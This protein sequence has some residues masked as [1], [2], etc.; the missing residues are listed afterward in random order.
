V[1]AVPVRAAS[2]RADLLAER[3]VGAEEDVHFTLTVAR[4]VIESYSQVGDWVLDPFLGYG[5][6]GAA[7]VELGR[8]CV[9]VELLEPRARS[10][11]SRMRA[12]GH[13]VVGDSRRLGRMLTCEVS[14]CLTSPPYMSAREHP[15]N[16][17]TGYATLDGDYPT[18]LSELA[19]TFRQVGVLLRPGGHLVLN[20]ADPGDDGGTPLV[21][22]L[23]ARVSAHLALVQRLPVEWDDPPPGLTNDTLLVFRKPA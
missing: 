20:V 22:D 8:R 13:V 15:Q 3:A 23:A 12:G 1:A 9:G 18:Y 14:L 16:P 17:L 11:R 10:A 7:A 6:T 21:D 5:T 4:T 2:R 19:D